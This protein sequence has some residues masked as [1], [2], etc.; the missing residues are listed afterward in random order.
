MMEPTAYA[1]GALTA[2]QAATAFALWHRAVS[3]SVPPERLLVLD[4]FT[5]G[6]DE[7]WSKLC[8]FV[9]RPLPP[10]D[11]ASGKLPPFPHQR[12]GEDIASGGGGP[13]QGSVEEASS[14]GG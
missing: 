3:A 6:D 2:E 4:L 13:P 7:L 1:M 12:Y 11:R 8:A 9:G 10:R 5:M 14:S